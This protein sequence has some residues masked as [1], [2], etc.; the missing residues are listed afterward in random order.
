MFN[1]PII[2]FRYRARNDLNLY[3]GINNRVR[4][5]IPREEEDLSIVLRYVDQGQVSLEVLYKEIEPCLGRY[6]P[7]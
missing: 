7:L 2:Y 5:I 1:F 6:N 4:K 3:Q